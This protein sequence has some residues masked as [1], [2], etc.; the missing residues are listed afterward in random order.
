MKKDIIAIL[1]AYAEKVKAEKEAKKG[2]KKK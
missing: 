1:K 2:A